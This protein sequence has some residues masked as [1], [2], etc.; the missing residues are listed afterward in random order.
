VLGLDA[1]PR[2]L[3]A[4]VEGLDYVE[5]PD[6]E[7]CCG[8]GGTFCVK[9]PA[10]STRMVEAKCAAIAATGADTVASGDLGCLMNIAG[11]LRREGKP[12][13]ARHVAEILAGA[14]D[15]PAIGAARG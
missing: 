13:A 15:A 12:V 4:S 5:L 3:L 9:Y 10:I 14:T 1:E 7:A 8:F 6:R 2:G 11:R